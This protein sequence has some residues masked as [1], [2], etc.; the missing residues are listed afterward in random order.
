MG[1]AQPTRGEV[2]RIIEAIGRGESE[3]AR[4]LLDIVYGELRA[5][6]AAQMARERPGHTLQPTALV[7]E[8]Y[9]R[10]MGPSGTPA[11]Q[12]RAHF[13]GAAGEAM[14]RILVD[15]ARARGA[16]KRGGGAR[17]DGEADGTPAPG[18]DPAESVDVLALHDALSRLEGEDGRMATIVKLR[19]FAG[20]TVDE[21]AAAL[22][23][24]RRTV[25]REWIAA[26]AWL[27][28][29]LD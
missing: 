12:N 16:Q 29:E 3:R 17:R 7:H 20:M 27:T 6:A 19:F 9:L 24:S 26:R 14:R 22:G 1:A 10:L 21:T 18:P 13:F 25:L 11:F 5:M 2:T 8:T 23:L 15:Q 28:A 4:E